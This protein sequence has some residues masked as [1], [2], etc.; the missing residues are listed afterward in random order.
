MNPL[1]CRQCTT[2]MLRN[3][4]NCIR[5][6]SRHYA[7][8]STGASR[9]GSLELVDVLCGGVGP[10]THG[11]NE[12]PGEMKEGEIRHRK[13]EVFIGDGSGANG[14]PYIVHIA[15]RYGMPA[16]LPAGASQSFEELETLCPSDTLREQLQLLRA[17][18]RWETLTVVQRAVIPLI[19]DHR[20]VLCIAPTATGKTF[21]YVFPSMLRLVL[22]AKGLET[23]VADSSENE[24]SRP[25]VE[26]LLK[27][28]IARGEICRYCELGIADVKVC[29]MTGTPH[30]PVPELLDKQLRGAMRLNELTSVAEPLVL[31]L[32]PTSQLAMQVHQLCTQLHVDFR[33]K[34]LVRASSAEEQKRHLNA[35]EGCDVLITTQE[36]MLPALYKRKLSLRRVKMLVMDEVDDLV[37]V[38]HFE[39]VKIILGALPK[40]H[41]RPQRLLFGASL[42]P[43]A[44][45]MVR[46]QMLL[47]SHRF[48]LADVKTDKLGHALVD[49]CST[50]SAA[51]THVVFMVSQVEKISKLARLY[52][53]GKLR[54][55]QRTLIFCNS[56][57]NVAY[58]AEQLQKLVPDLH[59]TTL[60]SR[61]SATGKMGT[62]KLFRSGVSTCLVCTDILSR[63]IDFHNVVY[64][65]HYD[66]PLEFDTWVHRSGRCGR[67]GVPGYCYTFFQPESVKLAKPLVAHLRQTQQLIPPKLQEYANQSLVDTFKSS[68][69]YHPTRPYRSGDP[70]RQHPVMGRGMPRFPDYK[71]ERLNKNFRPL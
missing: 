70:Q 41:D 7:I 34:F 6:S 61:S 53:T 2:C 40:G 57:H 12:V 26:A 5:L 36:T 63:G 28:K 25:N 17:S 31:I 42:P 37:S 27:D 18:R 22:H 45:Q 11:M 19:L 1:F 32:V 14:S 66:T 58:V 16:E 48:V 33:V 64:V 43:V 52:S 38:N 30:P 62:L 69:F 23:A 35:L 56:R 39:K 10:S 50:A 46:E 29:P 8:T 71:Q 67:H 55:D 20:D 15:D 9:K 49:G 54:P 44:Y 51:I 3:A 47:P 21:C 13:K 4:L 60:T 65:V 59:V 24:L 68:L